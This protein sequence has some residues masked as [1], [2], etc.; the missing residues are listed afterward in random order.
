MKALLI[1][2]S[3][4]LV[5]PA[6]AHPAGETV[7]PAFTHALTNVPGKKLIAARVDY[8]PGGASPAHHHA[9]SAFIYA[10]VLSGSIRSQVDDGPAAIYHTGESF[11]EEPGALH[12]I[13]ENASKTKPASLLAVFVVD[14]GDGPLTTPDSK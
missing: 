4:V 5:T 3:L 8:A 13:S 12:R 14:E 6:A 7:T 1:L 2:T 9:G 11:Y 10:Y